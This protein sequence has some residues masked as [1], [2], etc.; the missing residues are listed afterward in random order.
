M[1][2]RGSPNTVMQ[3]A[4]TNKISLH[5]RVKSN[6]TIRTVVYCPVSVGIPLFT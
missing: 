3:A 1:I 5:S 6:S 2:D 4:T